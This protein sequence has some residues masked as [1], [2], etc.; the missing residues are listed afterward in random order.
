MS[1]AVE[2][3]IPEEDSDFAREGTCGHALAEHRL[4][5]WLGY[6]TEHS[7]ESEVP[8]YDEFYNE[9]FSRHVNSFVDYVKE[10]V[11]ELRAQHGEDQV[12]VLLEQRLDFSRW[13][14]QGF[15]TADVV[16]IVPGKIIVIDLKF[17]AGVYVDGVN[18]G[19]IRLY[20][21]GAFERFNILY[22]FDEVEV[23]IH[24]PRMNNISGE[25][26]QVRG[27]GGILEWA[28]MVVK[29][30]AAI[31]WVA[32]NGDES[33]A[34]F[35]PGQ[36]C[37]EAFCKARYTC[38]ARARYMLE[39]AELPYHGSEPHE[40]TVEQMEAVVD[41]ADLAARWAKDVKA[42]LL[43]QAEKGTVQMKLH[44]L[45]EGRSFRSITDQKQAATV[46]MQNGFAAGDIYQPPEL[47]GLGELE[48]LVGKKKLTEILG[49]LL[50]KPAG[51]P[52]L[53]PIEDSQAVL[54]KSKKIDDFDDCEE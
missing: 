38:A 53:A 36:H 20:G 43:R 50:H 10:R 34:R 13:V 2:K 16:I 1:V 40:M 11:T 47:R 4:N 30:R 19:Q 51:K 46:L 49:D 8:D 32:Y 39:L 26:L 27:H 44:K 14:P 28:D 33:E 35:A 12:V 52:T 45:V 9:A 17:G 5:V 3:N 29:P 37:T 23:V 18:N 41:K 24:Q 7:E 6:P 22:D 42:Y 25:T 21:L 48:H 31:A 54:K 15:G